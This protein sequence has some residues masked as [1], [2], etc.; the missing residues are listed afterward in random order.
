MI[1][2]QKDHFHINL[3]DDVVRGSIVL[4]D[5]KLLWPPPPPKEVPVAP[6]PVA[7]TKK[8]PPPQVERNPFKETLTNALVYT[9][10]KL[11]LSYCD[12]LAAT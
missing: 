12:D 1:S 7:V 6:V 8:P 9:G 3:E 11:T 2:G 4:L 5:G 10:G